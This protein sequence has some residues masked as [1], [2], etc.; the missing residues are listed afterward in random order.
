[1]AVNALGNGHKKET[2]NY[3]GTV[4]KEKY[5]PIWFVL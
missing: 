2:N 5:E 1:M 4:K 3:F